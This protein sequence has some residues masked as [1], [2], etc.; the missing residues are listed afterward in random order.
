MDFPSLRKSAFVDSSQPVFHRHYF[1]SQLLRFGVNIYDLPFLL[2]FGV[3]WYVLVIHRIRVTQ[4]RNRSGSDRVKD[5]T[6]FA[7]E[8]LGVLLNLGCGLN[9]VFWRIA[10]R[11]ELRV[12]NAASAVDMATTCLANVGSASLGKFLRSS[13]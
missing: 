1:V 7:S 2:L 8:A 13:T 9:L 3:I 6:V 10:R 4:G 12:S 5:D 11:D